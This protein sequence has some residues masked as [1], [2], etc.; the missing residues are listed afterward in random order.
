VAQA[1]TPKP[2]NLLSLSRPSHLACAPVAMITV[3]ASQTWPLSQVRRNG[4][5]ERS[6]LT[7]DVADELGADM[8]GLGLHLLH[9]PGA[10]DDVGEAR[11][12]LDIGGDGQLAAGLD[13]G[14]QHG[15]QQ[16]ARGIDGGGV[17]GGP[18]PMIR[19]RVWRG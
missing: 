8:L 12:V 19:Q 7:D 2:W 5:L 13:A 17:A 6:A 10:L 9:Q 18:D 14:D 11:I 3:S 1:E 16:G 15:L 4:R